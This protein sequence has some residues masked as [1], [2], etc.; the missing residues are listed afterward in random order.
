MRAAVVT[1]TGGPGVIEVTETSRPS[2]GP[3]EALV[4]VAAAGVNFIDTYHRTGLYPIRTPFVLGLEGAGRVVEVGADVDPSLLGSRVAWSAVP[5]SYAEAVTAPADRLVPVPDGVPD[6]MA[7]AVMLQGLTAHYL[8][9]DTFSLGAGHRCLI[10]AAAGGVGSLLVQMAKAKGAEVFATAGGRDKVA[11]A[12]RLGAD[13]VIDY[14]ERPFKDAVE[15]IAG[16]KPLDV[17]YDGVGAATFDDGLDL[18]APRGL[19]VA[20]GNASGPVPPLD[21]LRL[22][23]GGSLYVTRPTLGTHTATPGALGR[24]AAELFDAIRSGALEVLIGE[25]FP[26]GE[27][28][29]AHAALE[30]R[31]TVGKVLLLPTG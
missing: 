23:R 21:I 1:S 15:E 27:A 25:R 18:L 17:V 11:I 6:Q 5:G 24:R 2:P 9:N 13:H 29:A 14:L 16:R 28:A 30:A 10:H 12:A 20:F 8:V 22:S 26:L 4:E 19:M 7:A 31:G 3:D